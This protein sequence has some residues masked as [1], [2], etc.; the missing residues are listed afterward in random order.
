MIKIGIVLYAFII[1]WIAGGMFYLAFQ[2]NILKPF[3]KFEYILCYPIFKI[4]EW[5]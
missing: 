1:L 3:N 2:K 5:E 4:D